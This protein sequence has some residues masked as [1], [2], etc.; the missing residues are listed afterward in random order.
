[1]EITERGAQGAAA[2]AAGIE[3]LGDIDEYFDINR[4]FLFFI[5]DYHSGALLFISRVAQPVPIKFSNPP[6][7]VTTPPT[8]QF[9]DN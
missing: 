1:M 9:Y 8:G 4:P 2:T 3:R 5:W 7:L 6:C